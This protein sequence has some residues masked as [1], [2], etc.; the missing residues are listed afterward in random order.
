MTSP[1]STPP[2][3]NSVRTR[4]QVDLS[5]PV[6]ALLDDVSATLGVPRSQVVLQA[7]LQALPALIEH[8]GKVRNLSRDMARAHGGKVR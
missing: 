6:A 5:A 8:A 7:F 3:L 4:L 1:V 2:T